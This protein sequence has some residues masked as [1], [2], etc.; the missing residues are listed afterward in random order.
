MSGFVEYLKIGKPYS[1]TKFLVPHN[2]LVRPFLIGSQ[3][4]SFFVFFFT[5]RD[6][7]TLRSFHMVG[8]NT[9]YKIEKTAILYWSRL[10]W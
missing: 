5:R 3:E 6:F 1:P 2:E 7:G 10:L 4:Y 9:K 8:R